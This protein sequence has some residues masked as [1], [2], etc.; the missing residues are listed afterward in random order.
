MKFRECSGQIN[1]V[2]FGGAHLQKTFKICL[3]LAYNNNSLPEEILK[4]GDYQHA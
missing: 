4:A 2:T 1:F 3:L